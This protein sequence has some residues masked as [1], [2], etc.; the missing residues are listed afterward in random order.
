[1]FLVE[2]YSFHF[3]TRHSSKLESLK[4]LESDTE[5]SCANIDPICDYEEHHFDYPVGDHHLSG[6][7]TIPRLHRSTYPA[8]ILI[9]GSGP[10]GRD[11]AVFT[12]RPFAVIA[13][14]LS[15]R[16]IA[17]LRYDKRG[18]GGSGGNLSG[19]T[20][21][22]LADDT[23][24]SFAFMRQHAMID[25]A[26][27]G[28]IGHSEGGIIASIVASRLKE[29][30]F[31]VLLGSPILPGEQILLMQKETFSKA[32]GFN[33]TVVERKML[34]AAELFKTIRYELTLDNIEE[35]LSLLI[36][37]LNRDEPQ[38][39]QKHETIS[40]MTS[41]WFRCF[42][43][44]DPGEF[45]SKITC[46]VFALYGSADTQVLPEPNLKAIKEALAGSSNLTTLELPGLN[47]M[48]QN[49]YTGL[50][51][52]YAHI[53]EAIAGSALAVTT[54]WIAKRLQQIS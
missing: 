29:V 34:E 46:P 33:E 52:E 1:M 25:P 7:L 10:F 11:A 19:A 13:D 28:L 18:I 27:V 5:L 8:A 2:I 6:T 47:H 44:L 24:A 26:R 9:H 15:R 14:Y 30:A 12:H 16:G 51:S 31:T 48:L 36:D 17:V 50:P 40:A 23:A 20:S 45:I 41:P 54:R 43:E 4:N 42:L 39:M 38:P 37:M 49:C 32:K 21:F 3:P 22:D 53:C 35:K